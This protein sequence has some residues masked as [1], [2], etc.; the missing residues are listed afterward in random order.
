[1]VSIENDKLKG[2]YIEPGAGRITFADYAENWLKTHPVDESTWELMKTRL[3]KH[4]FPYF[5][6]RALA[7]IKP[8]DIR[9]WDK[10]PEGQLAVNTKS[11]ACYVGMST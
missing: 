1:L 6:S 4:V 3:R 11:V 5:G 9:A 10:A 2:S 7:S 8:S